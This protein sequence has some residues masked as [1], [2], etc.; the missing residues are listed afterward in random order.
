MSQLFPVFEEE[1]E[2][3]DGYEPNVVQEEEAAD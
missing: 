2:A 1:S 3:S